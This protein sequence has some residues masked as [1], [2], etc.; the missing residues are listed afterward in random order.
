MKKNLL[1][2]VVLAGL[3][4]ARGESN[5]VTELP[6]LDVR[7]DLTESRLPAYST[8]TSSLDGDALRAREAHHLQDALGLVPNLNFAGA[9]S[10]PRY[11]QLRGVGE[12]SQFSGEGPPNFSVGVLMDD[13]DLSGLAGAASLFDL[14]SVDVLRGPQATVYGSRALA[15]LLLL[16]SEAPTPYPDH[17]LQLSL[18]TDAYGEVGLAGGGPWREG[19]ES[20]L[21]R[22]SLH[23]QRQ[24]GFRD[25][26][27]LDRGDTNQRQEFSSRFRLRYLPDTDQRWDLTLLG[28]RLDNGYDAF[29]PRGDGF[30]MY[31]DEPGKD[32][33]SLGGASLRGNFEGPRGYDVLSISSATFARSVY[34]YDADWAND[35]FWA[36]PPYSFDP[37]AEGYRYSFTERLDRERAQLGQEVRFTGK[38]DNKLFGQRSAWSA[39]VATSWL[40]EKDDYRGFS[41]LRSDYEAVTAAGYGQ[42]TTDVARGTRLITS[43]RLEH[44][45]SDYSDSGDVRFDTSDWMQGGRL[46]VETDVAKSTLGFL[47][48]SRG[49]KGGGV[50]TDPSLPESRRAYD[51]ENLWNLETGLRTHW[52]DGRGYANL[53]AFHMWREDLQV[54]TSIQPDPSDPTSFTF[55]TDNA[56]EG[57]NYGVEVEAR[58]PLSERL[59][60]FGALGLLETEYRNFEDAGGNPNLNGREQP[61]APAY[62]F[63][64]GLEME[65]TRHW[66]TRVEAEG[67]DSFVFSDGN[68][69]RSDPFVLLNLSLAYRADA[70]SVTFWGRNV[71]DESYDTR[72]YVFGLEPPD[73]PERL[74]TM[75]GDPA[76]FGLT[77]RLAF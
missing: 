67:K 65:W 56:A 45:G 51:P 38:E 33:L 40:S 53:T 48:L 39:G 26:E 42:L 16:T 50:N 58:V 24:D 15:G 43:L 61:H 75:K 1:A 12:R 2:L 27:F 73:Y 14:K 31:S 54:G 37:D 18:G 20:L 35:A 47:G 22:F 76:Q 34:A 11:L 52:A 29:A 4:L 41:A 13:I 71:L 60:W 8:S 32:T 62:T 7:P 57:R 72:G 10:R 19:D 63:N 30:R 68:D 64:T 6:G 25:N 66:V 21:Y 17:R 9:T 70:W 77:Y 74:W 59:A 23:A 55:F 46:A 3:A 49:F 44:R 28:T 69:A 36:A 5:T